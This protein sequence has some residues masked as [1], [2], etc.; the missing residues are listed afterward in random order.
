MNDQ[1]GVSRLGNE[2]LFQLARSLKHIDES[3][4]PVLRGSKKLKVDSFSGEDRREERDREKK[5]IE[6]MRADRAS[7]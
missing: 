4:S 5:M 1:S 7:E 6:E 3:L 2:P